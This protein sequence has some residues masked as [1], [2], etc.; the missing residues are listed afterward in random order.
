MTA[1][2][3]FRK[4]P[5]MTDEAAF[6]LLVKMLTDL[7]ESVDADRDE[8]KAD[9]RRAGEYRDKLRDDVTALRGQ[10]DNLN[11]HVGSLTRRVEAME[12]VAAQVQS[13]HARLLGALGLIGIIG[14]MIMG[15]VAFFKAEIIIWLHRVFGG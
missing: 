8:R 15:F 11:T 3:E 1:S 10:H 7:K 14:T 12:P 4:V 6:H 2:T 13:W 9:E 5:R